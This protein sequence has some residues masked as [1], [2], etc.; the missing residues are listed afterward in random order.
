[1]LEFL[2]GCITTGILAY[3]IYFFFAQKSNTG[4]LEVLLKEYKEQNIA[5]KY[6]I[7]S[8][9]SN[10]GGLGAHLANKQ[11]EVDSLNKTVFDLNIKLHEE[12][13]RN[14]TVVSQ[15]K[16][17]QVRVGQVA[18]AFSPYL[19]EG[20]DPKRMRFMGSPIDY[21][22]FGDDKVTFVEIKTGKSK[23]TFNQKRIKDQV[24]NKKIEW[25]EFRIS[26]D[27]KKDE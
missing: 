10:I 6:D 23:L 14:R 2:F 21:I 15:S 22:C 5:L 25:R 19:M 1:M 7:D 13:E 26:G 11:T 12:L 16:S 17:S 4:E 18:E 27:T 24:L 9:K 8:A 3:V 20:L